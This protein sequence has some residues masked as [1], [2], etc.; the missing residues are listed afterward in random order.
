MDISTGR[1]WSR[2]ANG[3]NPTTTKPWLWSQW[4]PIITTY[5]QHQARVG[6]LVPIT[7]SSRKILPKYFGF[8]MSESITLSRKCFDKV[9][10]KLNS[11]HG[12]CLRNLK[13]DL[14]SMV[15]HISAELLLATNRWR[16]NH[17]DPENNS[18]L[19]SIGIQSHVPQTNESR[20]SGR[21]TDDDLLLWLRGRSPHIILKN[22]NTVISIRY[23]I[24]L[25]KFHARLLCIRLGKNGILQHDNAQPHTILTMRCNLVLILGF[26]FL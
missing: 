15:M 13:N 26:K 8:R 14:N 12:T 4:R 21:K 23:A 3:V 16:T 19:S 2:T 9:H 24:T 22:D 11:A 1:R 5:K 25:Q 20:R 6:S 18:S 7:V 17:N 10:R